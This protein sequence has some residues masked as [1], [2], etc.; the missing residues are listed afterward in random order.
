MVTVY[1]IPVCCPR[2]RQRKTSV[3]DNPTI[4]QIVGDFWESKS[5]A[6]PQ[7]RDADVAKPTEDGKRV[8]RPGGGRKPA[9]PRAGAAAAAAA[10][11]EPERHS[12]MFVPYG[13]KAIAAKLHADEAVM[14]KVYSEMDRCGIP[15]SPLHYTTVN[16]LKPWY[17]LAYVIYTSYPP[18]HAVPV[19]LYPH[20]STCTH[21][22]IHL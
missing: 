19:N 4:R 18:V 11:P 10:R 2:R 14:A 3:I 15:R 9:R 8:R 6:S 13:C 22:C 1:I 16:K 20:P 21:A 12:R 17:R 7:V 5:I